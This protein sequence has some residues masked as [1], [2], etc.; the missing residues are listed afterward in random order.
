MEIGWEKGKSQRNGV[1]IASV[2]VTN[3]A[4]RATG[5]VLIRPLTAYTFSKCRRKV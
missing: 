1:E 5:I 2:R 4:L 3:R